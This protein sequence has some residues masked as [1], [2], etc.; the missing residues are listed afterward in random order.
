ML[1][2][3]TPRFDFNNNHQTLLSYP[4][5]GVEGKQEATVNTDL[6]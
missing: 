2:K 3:G 6:I 1:I 4:R 5:R